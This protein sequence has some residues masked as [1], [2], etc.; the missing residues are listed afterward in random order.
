MRTFQ[1]LI[2]AGLAVL[3]AGWTVSLVAETHDDELDHREDYVMDSISGGAFR[4]Y[5]SAHISEAPRWTYSM[6]TYGNFHNFMHELMSSMARYAATARGDDDKVPDFEHRISGGE[7]GA[8]RQALEEA[9]EDS[10]WRDL[11]QIT[12]IM[13]D[14]VHHAMA[15]SLIYDK[16]TYGRDVDLADYLRGERLAPGE[17]I[18]ES[19]EVRVNPLSLDE[20]RELAWRYEAEDK[21]LHQAVQQMIVFGHMLD[22]MLTQ[23]LDYGAAKEEAAC[24]P[25]EEAVDKRGQ[26]WS[27]YAEAISDCQHTEWREFVQVTALMRERIHHMMYKMAE[28]HE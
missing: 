16:E 11:V 6:H 17:G 18:P 19:D 1:H 26:G 24:Q 20:F 23:W 2:R 8:Y 10:A 4:D 14:R 22:D 28:Y 15:K 25:P 5:I 27:E 13:H 21:H 9:G 3:L 12:E 7:W